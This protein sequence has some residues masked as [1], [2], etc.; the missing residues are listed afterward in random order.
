MNLLY[1]ANGLHTDGASWA[2]ATNKDRFTTPGLSRPRWIQQKDKNTIILKVLDR[3][4][5]T[6]SPDTKLIAE[7]N[8]AALNFIGAGADTAM[9]AGFIAAS[10]AS[11]NSESQKT[12]TPYVTIGGQ[13]M[14]YDTGSY[15]DSN[16]YA[17]NLGLVRRIPNAN[18]VDTIMPFAE[19]GKKQLSQPPG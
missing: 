1:D 3:S 14:R 11:Q 10:Q 7:G 12:F 9:D 2:S 18:S 6:L 16:G 19:Y 4:A 8:A 17:G 5:S 13:N 15:V